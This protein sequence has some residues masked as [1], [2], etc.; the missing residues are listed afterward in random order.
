MAVD[1]PLSVHEATVRLRGMLPE[2][3]GEL[4]RVGETKTADGVEFR[5]ARDWSDSGRA[6]QLRVTLRPAEGGS[7][8]VIRT[9][10][11]LGNV[12]GETVIAACASGFV[13]Y[14]TGL[15]VW[16]LVVVGVCVV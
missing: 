7:R 8:A 15:S 10:A 3:L 5:A 2:E 4:A 13:I 14:K 16:S 11:S 9:E 1:S 12:L 6:F